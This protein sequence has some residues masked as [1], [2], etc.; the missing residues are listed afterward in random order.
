MNLYRSLRSSFSSNLGFNLGFSLGSNPG[1][2]SGI[3][4]SEKLNTRNG[5]NTLLAVGFGASLLLGL[6]GCKATKS[7]DAP[8]EPEVEAAWFVPEGIEA[9]EYFEGCRSDYDTAAQ[10]FSLLETDKK[11]QNDLALLSEIDKLDI[12][13][14]RVISKASLFRNVH[15]NPSVREA[16]DNCQQKVIELITDISL[17]KPLYNKLASVDVAPLSELDQRYVQEMLK[18]YERSG[19]NLDDAA[20]KR[21]RELSEEILLLGQTFN[22]NIRENVRTL[23]VDSVEQLKGLPQDYID[24]HQPDENGKI[25]LTTNYPDY[26]PVMQY[27]E[28]DELR[29][30]FYKEFRKRGYPANDTTLKELLIKRHELAKLLGYTNYA[31][32]VT[33]DLMIGTPENAE[34]F[35][36]KI[37]VLA[38]AQANTEYNLLLDRLKK[39]DPTATSVGDWQKTYLEE[40]VKTE[41]F[42]VDSQQIREYFNYNAVRDGIFNL[43][44]TM[45]GVKIKPWQT[46]LWH[47]SVESYE[48][49]EGDELIGKFYLDMHPRDGKYNHAAAFG[50]QDGV[51]GIQPPILALVCNFPSGS[52]LMEHSQVETFLHEFG[53]LL[54]GLFGGHQPRLYFSGIKPEHDF[55]EAPSQML[56]EWVWDVD[57]LKT[58][59]KNAKGET[60][61][62]HLI[63]KMNAGRNFGKALFSRHQMFYAAVSLNYYNTNPAELDLT[64]TMVELQKEYSPYSYVDD[65]YFFAS[66]GHLYGYSASYYTYMWSAVIATDMFSEFEKAGLRNTE[67]AKRYRDKVLAPGGSK[68]AAQMV[69][70]FL[71]RPYSFETFAKSLTASQ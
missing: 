51:K 2:N 26:I 37:N 19:V 70:D 60:I 41:Q 22:K 61:P 44:E 43:T 34:N 15:P 38:K 49:W 46:E 3:N 14:D 13:L 40:L 24:A 71:G 21:K 29:L 56:E 16:A 6:S 45:F 28:N 8:S 39:I 65:T 12:V 66:F 50:Y 1:S 33:E 10:L 4:L 23:E 7:G 47:E 62:N 58:F 69:E 31:E 57:T 59:A 32:Y 30:N 42:D 11:S 55:V 68:G 25:I 52:D 48:M 63:D 27:A 18:D 64:Q 36:N 17:S 20:R 35:I 9:I 67:V 53:H 54:H 5:L